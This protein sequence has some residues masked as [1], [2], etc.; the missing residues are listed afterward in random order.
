MKYS[1]P[2]KLVGTLIWVV[3]VLILTL[4]S[5]PIAA[6]TE[7]GSPVKIALLQS[8]TGAF[9]G[10][11]EQYEHGI[12]V[13]LDESG[14]KVA[15]RNIELVTADDASSSEVAMD[16]VRKLIGVDKVNMIVAPLK[17]EARSAI[18]P[19]C[20][21]E[22]V[23][24]INPSLDLIDEVKQYSTLITLDG[25]MESEQAGFG[26]YIYEKLGYKT[27]V[28]L[29]QEYQYGHLVVDSVKLG[30]KGKDGKILKEVY[31][32]FGT[33]DF[34]PYLMS[35]GKADALL[36]FVSAPPD[37]LRLFRQNRELGLRFPIV[38][39]EFGTAEPVLNDLGDD[40]VGAIGAVPYTSNIQSEINKRFVENHEKK[41][42]K[43]PASSESWGYQ[44]V[45]VYLQALE[46]TGGDTATAKVIEAIKKIKID[47]PSGR[48]EMGADRIGKKQ[49]YI[50]KAVKKGNL[51]VFEIID[52]YIN[53]MLPK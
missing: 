14:W 39:P 26:I 52:T 37:I 20:A 50:V 43:K 24:L 17:K 53:V 4:P 51:I 48:I 19:Y 32:P 40:V 18:A 12:R 23:V 28:V 35:L 41:Y 45:A 33:T 10:K 27:L 22:G 46:M 44:A 47:V 21:R 38:F 1:K 15:G 8:Y 49:W 11:G 29:S 9:A 16:K 42:G 5:T 7:K 30:Y 13:R 25:P 31:M 2:I 36:G 34:T 3:I 6:E